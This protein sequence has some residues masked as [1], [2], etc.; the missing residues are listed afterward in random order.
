MDVLSV[1]N[2]SKIQDLDQN[3]LKTAY[4]PSVTGKK[5]VSREADS[6]QVRVRG[7]RGGGELREAP[8]NDTGVSREIKSIYLNQSVSGELVE[9]TF[10]PYVSPPVAV[11]GYVNNTPVTVPAFPD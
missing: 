4:L 1:A 5:H 6:F 8:S 9:H 3:I 7:P 10:T 2:L 11:T